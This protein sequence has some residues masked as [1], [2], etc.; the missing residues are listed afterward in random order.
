MKEKLIFFIYFL[1]PFLIWFFLILQGN[2]LIV[3]I[4]RP[5]PEESLIVPVSDLFYLV[6]VLFFIQLSNLFLSKLLKVKVFDIINFIFIL[7]HVVVVFYI[8]YF[9]FF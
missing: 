7:F 4:K 2:N 9:N 1:T 6:F 5:F 3:L 8:F